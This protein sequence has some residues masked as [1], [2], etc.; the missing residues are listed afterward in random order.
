MV[1]D[2]LTS[3]ANSGSSK[4]TDELY[5]KY[6][7][8]DDVPVDNGNYSGHLDWVYDKYY[9]PGYLSH[10]QT[11]SNLR[12]HTNNHLS[13]PLSNLCSRVYLKQYMVFHMPLLPSMTD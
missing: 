5:K 4:K 2:T 12:D 11:I 6:S 3:L 9:E 7:S 13:L 8:S 1:T 10:L